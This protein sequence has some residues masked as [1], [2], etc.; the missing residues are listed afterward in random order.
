MKI[1]G[2]GPH[3]SPHLLRLALDD[4]QNDDDY[5]DDGWIPVGTLQEFSRCVYYIYTDVAL[6]ICKLLE[7]N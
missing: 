3:S 6:R 4:Y 1:T 5:D 2:P 7:T